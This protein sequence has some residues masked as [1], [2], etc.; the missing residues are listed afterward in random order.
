MDLDGAGSTPPGTPGATT[1]PSIEA[2]LGRYSASIDAGDFD[3]VGRLFAEGR[4]ATGDGTTLA[5][6]ATEVAALYHQTTRRF[7]DGT[8]RTR[9]LVSDLAVERA[10][11]GSEARVRSTFVVVQR[12]DAGGPL[13]VVAAGTYVDHVVH[14]HRGWRF[15][16]RRMI[17]DLFGDVSRHLT[18]DPAATPRSTR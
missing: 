2:L 7:A 3:G 17:P 11:T 18:F 13:L 1:E 10:P 4:L 6:G 12:P 14:D 9:H 8:P 5:S 15:A 16:E